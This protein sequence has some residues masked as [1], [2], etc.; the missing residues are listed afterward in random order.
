MHDL[1]RDALIEATAKTLNDEGA[2]P[3]HSIHSWRCE[4]PDRF[5]GCSCVAEV[6]GEVVGTVL[7][8]LADDLDR[9][10]DDGDCDCLT[11]SDV[12]TCDCIRHLT[13]GGMRDAADRIRSLLPSTEGDQT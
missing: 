5:G 12:T 1:T 9:E 10:A 8:L 11:D 7:R 2:A 13:V 4:Y 3:G 6:A